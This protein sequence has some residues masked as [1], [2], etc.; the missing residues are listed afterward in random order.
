MKVTYYGHACVAVEVAGRTLLFDP[1]FP[2]T[3]ARAS[4]DPTK[5]HADYILVSHGHSDHIGE[6]ANIAKRTGATVVSNFEITQWLGSKG[7]KKTWPLNL[8]GVAR[9]DFGTV[10]FVTAVHSSSLPDGSYGGCPGGFVVET[11]TGS[12]YFSGDTALTYDMKLIGESTRLTFAA[13][14]LGDTFTM[15]VD[16]ALRA[17]EFLQCNQILG[18]HYDTVPVIRIDRAAAVAKFA[19]AGKKLILLEVG[20]SYS[21]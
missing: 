17:A 6:A 19:A 4:L 12:F 14:C 8:G 1:Y 5:V 21:F 3:N 20:Q 15:G 11:P 7:V 2:A 13:L 16:D 18:M 9:L 10:K